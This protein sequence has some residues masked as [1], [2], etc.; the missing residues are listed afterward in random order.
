MKIPALGL[1]LLLLTIIAIILGPLLRIIFLLSFFFYWKTKNHFLEVISKRQKQKQMIQNIVSEGEISF[2][3]QAVDD[4]RQHGEL[5]EAGGD[6]RDVPH[7]GP[8]SSMVSPP[9]PLLEML[10]CLLLGF[11]RTRVTVIPTVTRFSPQVSRLSSP[12]STMS[13][14]SSILSTPCWTPSSPRQCWKN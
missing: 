3:V 8:P 4:N 11:R 7:Q 13:S 10:T 9:H 14:T 5:L 1:K 6:H 2:S 12:S